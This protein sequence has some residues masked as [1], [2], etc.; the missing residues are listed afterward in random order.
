LA[1]FLAVAWRLPNLRRGAIFTLM[2]AI[3]PPLPLTP[4]QLDLVLRAAADFP[5]GDR[6]RRFL[7]AMSDQLLLRQN[8]SNGELTQIV[9]A[10]RRA[11]V[12]GVGTPSLGP[13]EYLD[14]Y[15]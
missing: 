13:D 3:A 11:F 14:D 10:I 12:L 7:D 5:E 8:I 4:E 6:R 1:S 15:A 9:G 2:A